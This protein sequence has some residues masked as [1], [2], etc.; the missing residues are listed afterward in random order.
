MI[1]WPLRLLFRKH[2][3]AARIVEASRALSVPS[4]PT[5][6]D[7]DSSSDLLQESDVIVSFVLM[8]FGMKE[9]NPLDF[10]RFYSK[11][12]PTRRLFFLHTPLVLS[13]NRNVGS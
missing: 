8:H 5:T 6:E 9:K 7:G 12:D 10:I 11:Q 3:T 2:I 4:T 1:D 13:I